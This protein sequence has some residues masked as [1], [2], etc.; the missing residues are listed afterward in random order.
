MISPPCR[1]ARGEDRD[2][3]FSRFYKNTVVSLV[4]R[5]I[6]LGVP[7]ADAPGVVQELMVEIYRRWSEIESAQAY[8]NFT[9]ACRATD[10]LKRSARVMVA[11]G[12]G[13]EGIGRPL[14]LGLA[15]G[16]LLV[17]G[18]RLVME[19]LSQ[20]TPLQRAVFALVYDGYDTADIAAILKLK[21]T[22]VRSHLRHAR[23]VL[24]AWWSSRVEEKEGRGR[25]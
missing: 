2:E 12:T 7:A 16:V 25:P 20:L 5:C 17:E 3:A 24:R 13:L 1:E 23:T 9:V 14:T 6:L 19:A 15:D 10:Y 22:T 4:R 11:E 18:E 21:T 8:A